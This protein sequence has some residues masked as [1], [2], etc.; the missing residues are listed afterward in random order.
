MAQLLAALLACIREVP[1]LHLGWKAKYFV[2]SRWL[3]SVQ[4][5]CLG[6]TL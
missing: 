3:S 2:G 1:S 4:E 6:S 5:E